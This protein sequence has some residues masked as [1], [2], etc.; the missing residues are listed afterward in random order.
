MDYTKEQFEKL[1]KWAQSEI[2]SLRNDNDSLKSKLLQYEGMEQTNTYISEGPSRKPLPNSANVEFC[3]GVGGLNKARVY[4]RDN[5]VID[6]NT[7]SRL[8]HEMVIRPRAANSFYI[9]FVNR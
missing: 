1:P 2:T 7:D 6:V 3:V 9:D 5:G 4:V 8:G